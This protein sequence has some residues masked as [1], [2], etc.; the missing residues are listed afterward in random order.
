MMLPMLTRRAAQVRDTCR[1]FICSAKSVVTCKDA[2]TSLSV[3]IL[4]HQIWF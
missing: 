1:A 3:S 4:G 2:A